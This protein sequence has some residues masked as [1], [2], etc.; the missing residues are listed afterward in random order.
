M[1]IKKLDFKFV[2][3]IK[4][5]QHIMEIV[6]ALNNN[7][8][9]LDQIGAYTSNL[10][11]GYSSNNAST[12]KIYCHPVYMSHATGVG[13]YPYYRMCCLIFN[14]DPTPFTQTTFID[15]LK[16]L[17]ELTSYTAKIM[18]SGVY[19][20]SESASINNVAYLRTST[21]TTF[22]IGGGSGSSTNSLSGNINELFTSDGEFE[23]G[24]NAI[25]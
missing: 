12:K 22:F 11:G 15:Y 10:L 7:A 1:P 19:T 21:A 6:E 8:D 9:V 16:S 13:N 18:M 17:G 25:N 14:N 3:E 2:N 4:R 24:V 23:D 5:N 20:Q